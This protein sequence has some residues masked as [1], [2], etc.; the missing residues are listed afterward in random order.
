MNPAEPAG[1]PIISD[2]SAENDPLARRTRPGKRGLSRLVAATA[3]SWKGLQAAWQSEEAFRQEASLALLFLPLSYWVGQTLTHQL[4]LATACGLVILAE[5]IN[6]AIESIID[7]IGPEQDPL[8]GQAK[9]LGSAI[10]LVTLILF[11]VIWVPSLWQFTR[12][13]LA[14]A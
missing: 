8:S 11:L 14:S 2:P 9:D 5:L 1:S 10:V 3:N 6:T 13:L 4:L 12:H 7:R